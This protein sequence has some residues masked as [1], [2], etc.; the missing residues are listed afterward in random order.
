VSDDVLVAGIGNVFLGDDGFGVEVAR[1]LAAGPPIDGASVVDFGI[2]ALHLSYAL[3]DPPRLLLVVD[4]CSRGEAPGTLFVLEPEDLPED[5][6]ALA[7]A[8]SMSLDTVLRSLRSLGG[9]PPPLR[10]V[11]CEPA[12]LD[13]GMGLSDAVARAVPRAVE[14][15]RREIAR[16]R[17]DSTATQQDQERQP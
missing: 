5:D 16:A 14:L 12:C 1:Q 11:A 4:A 13:E 17:M 10:I 9:A 3:L 7:D 8:H 6:G 15:V 2:R